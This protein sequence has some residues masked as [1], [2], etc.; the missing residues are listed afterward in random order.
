MESKLKITILYESWGDEEE[1]A[2]GTKSSV[3]HS[4]IYHFVEV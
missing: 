2:P 3:V 1:A 4:D